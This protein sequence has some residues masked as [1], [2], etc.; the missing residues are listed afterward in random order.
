VEEDLPGLEV[1]RQQQTQVVVQE[2]ELLTLLE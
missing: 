2:V 1:L